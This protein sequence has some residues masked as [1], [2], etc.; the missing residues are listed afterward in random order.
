[1]PAGFATEYSPAMIGYG[2]CLCLY[3]P[4]FVSG[5][6]PNRVHLE[7]GEL[8]YPIA[9]A[10]GDDDGRRLLRVRRRKA[11]QGGFSVVGEQIRH[12]EV[13]QDAEGQHTV[14]RPQLGDSAEGAQL[15]G[16]GN[17]RR[18]SLRRCG[19]LGL[20]AGQN[21]GM[22]CGFYPT[23]SRQCVGIHPGKGHTSQTAPARSRTPWPAPPAN[24]GCGNRAS[25]R[26]RR[27]GR[28]RW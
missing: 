25:R 20:F 17:P 10:V 9:V 6:L 13:A 28:R 7:N 21:H 23:T 1:M 3:R 15:H 26:S 2:A 12:G 4:A 27:P 16:G 11:G 24:R 14:H 5:S 8:L 22:S 19:S 18:R